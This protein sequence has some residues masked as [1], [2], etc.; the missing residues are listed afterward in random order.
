M[1]VS[2]LFQ[3]PEDAAAALPASETVLLIDEAGRRVG[4]KTMAEVRQMAAPMRCASIIVFVVFIVAAFLPV[5]VR[6]SQR[7]CGHRHHM[8]VVGYTEGESKRPVCR[9]FTHEE[10]IAKL[11]SQVCGLALHS[12]L[13]CMHSLTLTH[14]IPQ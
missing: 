14:R 4:E 1:D 12:S 8:L 11:Q 10:M 9:L 5:H 13:P 7:H 6:C 3:S 2:P